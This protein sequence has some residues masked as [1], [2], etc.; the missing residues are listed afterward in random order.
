VETKTHLDL[1]IWNSLLH[2]LVFVV[3]QDMLVLVQLGDDLEE[4]EDGK[5]GDYLVV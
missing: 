1:E 4:A 2:L 5:I 3:L